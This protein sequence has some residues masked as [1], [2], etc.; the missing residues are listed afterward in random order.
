MYL[1]IR[2]QQNGT[3][4]RRSREYQSDKG[5]DRS[6]CLRLI[7][8]PA[9]AHEK[10][11]RSEQVTERHEK[12]EKQPA[13]CFHLCRLQDEAG[14]SYNSPMPQT[15]MLKSRLFGNLQPKA[16]RSSSQVSQLP[17]CRE[18]LATASQEHRWS[19]RLLELA[20]FDE[21]QSFSESF[22]DLL[23]LW[24]FQQIHR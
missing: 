15:Q 6:S 5:R 24:F 9:P 23:T 21:D 4:G 7:D 18:R 3:S 11:Q 8:P 20:R 13:C 14:S 22:K 2:D 19:Q 10:S 12:C 17:V 16:I 1:G